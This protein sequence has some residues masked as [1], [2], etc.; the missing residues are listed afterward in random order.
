MYLDD[1]DLEA[2]AL[3]VRCITDEWGAK[4]WVF[5]NSVKLMTAM[6]PTENFIVMYVRCCNGNC[7][8]ERKAFIFL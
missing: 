4:A 2:D 7:K 1:D 6:A 5:L 8:R 3:A